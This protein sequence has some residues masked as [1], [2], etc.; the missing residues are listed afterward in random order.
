[1]KFNNL[2]KSVL[3]ASALTVASFGANAGAIATATL[4][5]F[6]F[7]LFSL[8]S[9]GPFSGVTIIDSDFN[10]TTT[11]SDGNTTI[12]NAA[13]DND[14]GNLGY[15]NFN[16]S[17]SSAFSQSH[18]IFEEGH[19]EGQVFVG[20]AGTT[21]ANSEVTG[22]NS[23]TSTSNLENTATFSINNGSGDDGEELN[24]GF[25][26]SYF[27][28]LIAEVYGQGGTA[29]ASANV[30]MSLKDE[31]GNIIDL[32]VTPAMNVFST[33]NASLSVTTEDK[34]GNIDDSGMVTRFLTLVEDVEYT[35][36][37][38]QNSEVDVTSVPEPTSVAILGLGL[39]GLAGAA[40]RRK[41]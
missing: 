17:A 12:F 19:L 3:A 2:T 35:L 33:D 37:I 36:F 14:L 27:Y 16:I 34:F 28:E 29:Q 26:F 13:S 1:M 31:D 10:G 18:V 39:L 24:L 30:D 8:D 41:S 9:E 11:A 4:D 7:G 15:D 22:T 25:S 38:Q 23:A 21:Y 32:W 5:V 20:S 6:D 40:R